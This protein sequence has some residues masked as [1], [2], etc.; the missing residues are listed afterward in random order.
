LLNSA[1]I[2]L[3]GVAPY[4]WLDF[5]NNRAL[6]ASVDVGNVTQATGYSFT[7]ASDGYYTNADGTLT[8][9]GSGA[10]RRGDRGVLIEGSRTNLLL[11]SQE[12]NNASWSKAD[13]TVSA[14]QYTAPDGTLTM[15]RML[16]SAT[17]AAHYVAQT[18]TWTAAI[19]C[20]SYFVRY[21][22]QQYFQITTWDGTTSR[23]MNFDILNGTVGTGGNATGLISAVS[24]GYRCVLVT[25]T[26]QAA[27]GGNVTA[28]L[29]NSSSAAA[30]SVINAA[31]TE[32]YGLWGAQIEA[33]AFP[34]SYIPTVAAAA[35]RAADVLTYT[36]N[37]TAELAAI[38]AT[39]PELVTNGGFATDTTGWS[40]VDTATISAVGGRLRVVV[41]GGANPRATLTISGL[42]IG[43][44][45]R[46]AGTTTS[47]NT[48]CT[49]R[50]D[51]EGFN[52]TFAAASTSPK[53][54]EA[55]FVATATSHV[56]QAVIA[57]A[58]GAPGSSFA[59]FDDISVKLIPANTAAI[60]PLS[61]WAEFER[62]VDTGGL[63]TQVQ[64]DDGTG[65]NRVALT[66][67]ST[68]VVN[69]FS[70]VGGVAQSSETVA[71]ALAIG[72]TY[73]ASVR[74]ASNDVRMARGGTL[75]AGDVSAT[76]PPAPTTIRIG[77]DTASAEPFG[78]IRRAA[79]FNS[80]LTDA[81]L[82]T[83]ST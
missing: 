54:Y 28:T 22:N 41:G 59:E 37:G 19:H 58:A 13:V 48:G 81:Q 71:G 6:Y 20:V 8:L 2:Y 78:Y 60:Y 25:S 72:T 74:F 26:N 17:N 1:T 82:Q 63:E 44:T 69:A 76:N 68:D 40:A 5:I 34:S 61:L 10:L 39:Q 80:A 33:G 24:G 53:T 47:N 32:A 23:Y 49:A 57:S 11:R 9:F 64:I 67:A 56:I 4:H 45:Y 50:V 27:A 7:R 52:A 46:L 16:A 29:S 35:T 14:N 21:V 36:M 73:K 79:V 30:N 31:G 15:D 51:I 62:A 77:R 18:V 55:L 70:V 38:A 42:T 83:V 12:F 66:V 3:G 75:S 43:K 65:N